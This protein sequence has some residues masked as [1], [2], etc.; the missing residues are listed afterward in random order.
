MTTK[1]VKCC[2]E[3]ENP[4]FIPNEI[5]SIHDLRHTSPDDDFQKIKDRLLNIDE[6][7]DFFNAIAYCFTRDTSDGEDK[8]NNTEYKT[9]LTVGQMNFILEAIRHYIHNVV[10][11]IEKSNNVWT[12]SLRDEGCTRENYNKIRVKL[13]TILLDIYE[14]NE[15]NKNNDDYMISGR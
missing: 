4:Y 14:W 5:D 3:V 6:H 2:G 12:D 13:Y 11:N 1:C 9:S 7:G 10:Y 8:E 15:N